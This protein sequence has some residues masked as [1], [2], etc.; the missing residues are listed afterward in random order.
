MLDKLMC[1]VV[2]VH[3]KVKDLAWYGGV[4]DCDALAGCNPK[5]KKFLIKQKKKT[6]EKFKHTEQ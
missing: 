3:G 6:W 4:V 1:V 2:K 5:K